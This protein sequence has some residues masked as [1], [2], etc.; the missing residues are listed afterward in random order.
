MKNTTIILLSLAAVISTGCNSGSR[1]SNTNGTTAGTTSGTTGG[2][3][4]GTTGGTTSGTTTPTVG[5][6]SNGPDLLAAR[7]QHTATVLSDG[8][9]LVTGGADGQGI[10]ADSEVFDPLTNTWE[11]V[12]NLVA[13]PNDGLMMDVTDAFPTARQ[14][15]TATPLPGGTVLVAGGLGVER[16]DPQGNPIFETLTTAYT[17]DPTTNSFTRVGALATARAWHT[18]AIS[19]GQGVVAGGLDGLLASSG[20]ADIFDATAGTFTEIQVNDLHTWG[21][22]VSTTNGALIVG[23]AN[24]SQGT[25][26]GFQINGFPQPRCK[27]IAT[28]AVAAAPEIANDTIFPGV[29]ANSAGKVLMAGGQ[30]V[31]GQALAPTGLSEVF[32]V[33]TQTWGAGPTL[34][35]ERF[36]AEVSEIAATGDLLIVGGIDN[37]GALTAVCEVYQNSSNTLLGT[38]NMTTARSDFKV[39]TLNDGRV[40]VTG[41]LDDQGNGIIS[42]EF[43]TR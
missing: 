36:G 16:M 15:H 35:T 32:D 13:N 27:L 42:S 5:T 40:L 7:G 33:A 43:H 39:V 25:G 30:V 31:V 21:A 23:G 29:A 2:T 20:T 34:Q 18:A 3:T 24:V 14:L 8:R 19:G 37:T 4:S 1:S 12:R 26:G 41:G 28:G 6:F 11:I 17:F 9:V 22:M 38:V 10:L